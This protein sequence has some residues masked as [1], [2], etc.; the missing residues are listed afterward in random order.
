MSLSINK[1]T[2]PVYNFT[3]VENISENKN[4]KDKT[5]E[6]LKEQITYQPESSKY[7]L[8]LIIPNIE[9]SLNRTLPWYK[10]E[11]EK[12]IKMFKEKVGYDSICQEVQDDI[13]RLYKTRK[14]QNPN[15]SNQ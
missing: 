10:E 13:K 11:L 1:P 14:T 7:A 6:F 12:E 3:L 5:V 8:P 15:Q 9:M 2:I 4:D